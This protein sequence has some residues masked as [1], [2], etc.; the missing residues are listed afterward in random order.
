METVRRANDIVCAETAAPPCGVVIFGASGDLTR[1]KL[2]PA[3]FGLWR[4]DL[5]PEGFFVLGFARTPMSDE[6]FRERVDEAIRAAAPDG[7]RSD[8][9]EFATACSYLAGNY[10]DGEA[11]ARLAERLNTLHRERGTGGNSLF[12]VTAPT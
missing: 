2:L 1:R 5:L 12:N 4:R 9:A 6:A 11:Y 7:D 10:D 3:L 8:I